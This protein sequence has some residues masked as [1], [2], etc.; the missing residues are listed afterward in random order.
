MRTRLRVYVAHQRPGSILPAHQAM[1]CEAVRSWM[2]ARRCAAPHQALRVRR[3]SSGTPLCHRHRVKRVDFFARGTFGYRLPTGTGFEAGVRGLRF[4]AI[5]RRSGRNS[6]STGSVIPAIGGSP[7]TAKSDFRLQ[8]GTNLS[9]FGYLSPAFRSAVMT[10]SRSASFLYGTLFLIPSSL[11]FG[12][13]RRTSAASARASF[14]RP[15]SA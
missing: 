9:G 8:D 3:Q 10:R 14:S 12:L 4:P 13:I 1:R 5:S 11:Q 15:N 7:E 2:C 6:T